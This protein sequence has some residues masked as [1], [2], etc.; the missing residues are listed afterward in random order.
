[1]K[2]T[3]YDNQYI[4]VA[5]RSHDHCVIALGLPQGD[6]P[7]SGR[8]YGPCKGIVRRPCGLPATITGVYDHFWAK[9]DTLKSC[10]VLTITARCPYGVRTMS[11]QCVYGLR[12]YDYFKI[13]H[14][15]ELNKIVEA[16][17]SVNP[18][19]DRKVSLW[20]PH[21]YGD[22]D[23]VRPSFTRRKANVIEV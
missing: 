17:M 1:M 10:V 14:Y 12:A 18:Y 15:V 19:D 8:F 11:L 9:N 5:K 7:M 21:G 20:R 16:T 23:I 4:P 3:A 13:C 2:Q 6:R 22:L